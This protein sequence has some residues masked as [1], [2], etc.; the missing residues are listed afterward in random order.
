MGNQQGTTEEELPIG[1]R[2]MG[3][4]ILCEPADVSRDM[5]EKIKHQVNQSTF[6]MK[7]SGIGGLFPIRKKSGGV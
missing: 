4:E 1:E 7:E 6:L 2:P 3:R 5:G